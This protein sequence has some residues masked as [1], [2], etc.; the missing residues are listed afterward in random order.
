MSTFMRCS[1]EP[2]SNATIVNLQFLPK[3]TYDDDDDDNDDDD[4]DN[5]D[6]DVDDDVDNDDDDQDGNK[7]AAMERCR[8]CFGTVLR[9]QS[10]RH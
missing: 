7:L 6:D 1:T 4:V 8:R 5:D 2:D 3:S 10:Q 9:C